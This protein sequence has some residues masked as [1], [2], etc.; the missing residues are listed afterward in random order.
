MKAGLTEGMNEWMTHTQT[1]NGKDMDRFINERP[2]NRGIQIC[3]F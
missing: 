1:V 3:C 2:N